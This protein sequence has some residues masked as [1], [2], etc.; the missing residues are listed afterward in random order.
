MQTVNNNKEWRAKVRTT[1]KAAGKIKFTHPT[2][3]SVEAV[4]NGSRV[5][6]WDGK[7]GKVESVH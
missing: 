7:V 3:T 5:G 2:M 1:H 6:Y 4:Q